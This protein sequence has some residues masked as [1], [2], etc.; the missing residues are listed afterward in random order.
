MSSELNYWIV[1]WTL[2]AVAALTAFVAIVV[3][4]K[5]LDRKVS[6]NP[7]SESEQDVN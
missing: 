5:M 4:A 3:G 6:D 7:D 2:M 1:A